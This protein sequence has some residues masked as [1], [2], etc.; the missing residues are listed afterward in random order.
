MIGTKKLTG[1]DKAY[2]FGIRAEKFA[3]FFLRL[4]GYR[5]IAQRYQNPKGEIDILA[6]KGNIMAVVEVKARQ[7]F[8]QCAY[9]IPEWK[10]QKILGATKWLMAGH[11][12]ISGLAMGSERIIRFDAILV[13]P[14]RLPKHIKDAW[15][16]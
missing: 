12:K 8:E 9:S 14:R 3:V 6:V 15:R 13:I 5:I 16:I 1:K 4:K 7:S 10:Q 2:Q 11:G